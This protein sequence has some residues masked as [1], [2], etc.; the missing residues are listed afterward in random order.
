MLLSHTLTRTV[1]KSCT[2]F[3]YIPPSGLGGDSMMDRQTDGW[4]EA[5]TIYPSLKRG[6][7]HYVDTLLIWSYMG[8]FIY[9]FNPLQ[10][11]TPYEVWWKS[12]WYIYSDNFCFL[13]EISVMVIKWRPGLLGMCK[14]LIY[15]LNLVH[16]EYILYILNIYI[17]Y[18][19]W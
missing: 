13:A 10:G 4:T 9:T 3:G 8:P 19:N 18:I 7:K 11:K 2:K 1:W 14:W 15:C 5:F 12:L 16:F 17:Y 6:D